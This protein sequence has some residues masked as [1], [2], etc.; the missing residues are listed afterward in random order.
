MIC[1]D[2]I[3]EAKDETKFIKNSMVKCF[4]DL[5]SNQLFIKK[6]NLEQYKV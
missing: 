1:A 5:S 6:K 4:R 3:E 2:S